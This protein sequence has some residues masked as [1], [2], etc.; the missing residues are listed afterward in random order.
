MKDYSIDY[1]VKNGMSEKFAKYYVSC[2]EAEKSHPLYDKE[3]AE[4][5]LSKGFLFSSAKAYGLSEINFKEYLS[6]EDFYTVWPLNGWTRIWVDDKMTLKYMLQGTR[7]SSVMPRYYFYSTPNGV[8]PLI[9]N[10]LM[11]GGTGYNKERG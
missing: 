7:F 11:G 8:N 5:A 6:D 2:I 3:Y 4:W 9:D 1:F 10:V